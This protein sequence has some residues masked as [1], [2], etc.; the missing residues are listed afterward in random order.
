MY[1]SPSA[2]ILCCLSPVLRSIGAQGKS[3]IAETHENLRLD[4]RSIERS[5]ADKVVTQESLVL[6]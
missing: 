3:W 5:K 1:R 2:M 6:G 4:L